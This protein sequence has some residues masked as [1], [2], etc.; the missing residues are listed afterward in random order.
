M[1]HIVMV[2]EDDAFLLKAY[3]L[4]LTS[5]GF[6]VLSATDGVEALELL[7]TEKPEIILLDLV[8]PRMDGFATLAE[9]KKQ[10]ALQSIPIIV[11][12][13]LGQDDE[14]SRVKAMGAIDF[15]TKSDLSMS[16]LVAKLNTVLGEK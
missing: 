2:V 6:T 14:I 5:A 15:I 1:G 7:K 10:P 3:Q 8:M 16:D 13:N 11:A 9:I 4:K 12:S